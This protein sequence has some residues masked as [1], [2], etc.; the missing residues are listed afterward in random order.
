MNFD[1]TF[2]KR[3]YFEARA[4][5]TVISPLISAST[6]IGVAYLYIQDIIPIWI[7]APLFVLTMAIIVTVIGLKFRKIQLATDEDMKYER[8]IEL[9]KTLLEIMKALN[10]DK[11]RDKRFT[12][13]MEWIEK[14]IQRKI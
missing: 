4:G 14:I 5:N 9:N 1:K 8:Q 3:R 7:F 12:D 2:L 13:R 11:Q 10:D 6:F